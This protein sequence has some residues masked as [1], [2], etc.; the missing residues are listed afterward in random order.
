MCVCV[1]VCVCVWVCGRE[2]C[3]VFGG[4]GLWVLVVEYKREVTGE[5]GR[6][7]RVRVRVGSGV[8]CAGGGGGEVEGG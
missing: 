7:I 5:G 2:V 1:H 6:V 3:V 4:V 8:G